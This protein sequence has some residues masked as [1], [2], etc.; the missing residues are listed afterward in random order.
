M[1]KWSDLPRDVISELLPFCEFESLLSLRRC[2]SSLYL[3][4][5]WYLLF[6]KRFGRPTEEATWTLS[7]AVSN[8]SE[9]EKIFDKRRNALPKPAKMD[10]GSLREDLRA[11]YAKATDFK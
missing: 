1:A 7:V 11:L 5:G 10:L 3:L 6:W 4:I 9:W 2:H 8:N